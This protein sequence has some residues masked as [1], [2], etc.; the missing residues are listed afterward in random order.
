MNRRLCRIAVAFARVCFA[1]LLPSA[2]WTQTGGTVFDPQQRVIQAARV[3]LSC[4]RYTERTVTNLDGDFSFPARITSV[5]CILSVSFPGFETLRQ[6][7]DRQFGHLSVVLRVKAEKQ[8]VT[9]TP[10]DLN[11]KEIGRVGIGSIS[12][13]DEDLKGVSN[14]TGE[15]VRYAEEVAGIGTELDAIYVDGLPTSVLPPASMVA[16]IDVN[17]NPFSAEF[18]D[19]DFTHVNITTKSGDRHLRFNLGVSGLGLGGGN[20]IAPGLHSTAHGF[21]FS[22][23]G[24]VPRIPLTFSLHPNLS[25]GQNEQPIL[26]VFSDTA[27]P[28][29]NLSHA[30]LTTQ[31]GA[32]QLGLHASDKKNLQTDLS[33]WLSLS[34]ASNV[35]VGGLTLPAAGSSLSSNAT[36]LRVTFSDSLSTYT[37]HGGVVLDQ[38]DSKSGANSTEQG[39]T[40]VGCFVDGGAAMESNRAHRTRLTWKN[41][42]QGAAGRRIWTGGVTLARSGISDDEV[43]NRS[44]MLEFSSLSE[45]L[46]SQAG[47]P[48][49]TLFLTR[50]NGYSNLASIVA[51]PFIQTDLIHSTNLLITG[52]L[53]A[54]FQ[55][56]GGTL[57]SPRVSFA[58]KAGQLVFRGGAGIFVHDWTTDILQHVIEN[59][60]SHLETYFETYYPTHSP[61]GPGTAVSQVQSRLESPFTRRRDF[62]FRGSIERRSAH[63]APGFEYEIV[64]G[65]HMLGSDRT[66]GPNGWIDTLQSN[67]A[68]FRQHLHGQLHFTSRAHQI[69]AHYEWID[70]HDDTAGPFTFPETA[71][72]LQ[73]EWSRTAGLPRNNFSIVD[74]IH[75]PKGVWA[76]VT[77]T[78]HGSAP[79]NITSGLDDGNGLFNDRGGRARNSGNG[80]QY[81]ALD[82]SAYRDLGLPNPFSRHESKSHIHLGLQI[83]NLLGNTNYTSVDSVATSP[84]FGKPI[85]A[86]PGRSV[87]FWLTFN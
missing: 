46:A 86:A 21:N 65:K 79:Y 24:P 83:N 64:D 18:S 3:M 48:G 12:L 84:S 20:A 76:T 62:V 1:L 25:F 36:E 40:V 15:L 57:F 73:R 41:V 29:G 14:E 52:G 49:G 30:V 67:R 16:R 38:F 34:D 28:P 2:A 27:P 23:T 4:G 69:A 43:P 6:S 33:Y 47:N 11:L 59:D 80:P 26:A 55:T 22:L 58:A 72:D 85:D 63:L 77:E 44:G 56:G 51:A 82:L 70:S 9:V 68:Q 54:D 60:G 37:Y 8:T 31:N 45:Y 13:S 39:V 42:I 81:N 7:L 66:P 10:D 53:R 74:R 35:G 17:T 78:R 19:N 87:R 5:N 50:G 32:G 61:S 75:L 71:G